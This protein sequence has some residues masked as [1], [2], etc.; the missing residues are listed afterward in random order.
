MDTSL[1]DNNPC[2]NIHPVQSDAITVGDE[3]RMERKWG[4][5]VPS[6]CLPQASAYLERELLRKKPLGFSVPDV[7]S[8]LR[9]QDE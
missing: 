2:N 1:N 4:R 3:E 7:P 8:V 5:N 6:D 9:I